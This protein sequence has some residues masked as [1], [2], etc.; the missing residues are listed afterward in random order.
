MG[1]GFRYWFIMQRFNHCPHSVIKTKSPDINCRAF[2]YL[3]L[4][5]SFSRLSLMR[6]VNIRNSPLLYLPIL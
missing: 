4:R 2:Y 3:S 1:I 6:L 5:L